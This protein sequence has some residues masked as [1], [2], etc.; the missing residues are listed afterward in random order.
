[1]GDRRS[2]SSGWSQMR[3]A[4]VA[5]TVSPSPAPAAG[6]AMG[7][8]GGRDSAGP[9]KVMVVADPTRESMGALEWALSH[10]LL[11]KDQLILLHVVP[12]VTRRSSFSSLLKW[13]PANYSAVGG[14]EG[15]GGG[16]VVG[17]VGGGGEKDF[18]DA[19]KAACESK[20]PKT[21][22]G[23][24]TVGMEAEGKGPTILSQTRAHA[25]DLLIIGQR[26]PTF[27]AWVSLS[28]SPPLTHTPT[29]THIFSLPIFYNVHSTI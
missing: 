24:E 8:A 16:G 13:P 27:L 26:R 1:M 28:L 15:G 25:V 3:Q 18:L 9:R 4:A 17:C 12:S 29:H 14:V 6:Q 10:A 7:E 22:V 19:M 2:S 5:V 20:L 11:D 23:V 21:R